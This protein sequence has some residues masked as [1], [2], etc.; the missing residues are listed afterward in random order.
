MS[1]NRPKLKRPGGTYLSASGMET[2]KWESSSSQ[3]PNGRFKTLESED[4]DDFEGC[5]RSDGEPVHVDI[6]KKVL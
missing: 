6:E 3:S 1:L 2:I 5:S 4:E